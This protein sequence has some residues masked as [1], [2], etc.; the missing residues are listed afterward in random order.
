M[1]K[2]HNFLQQFFLWHNTTTKIMLQRETRYRYR[3]TCTKAL[4]I[5][6]D[7]QGRI[8]YSL[9]SQPGAKKY[10]TIS[11]TGVSSTRLRA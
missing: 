5:P 7:G 8:F 10:S 3:S 11:A 2:F 4:T 6:M 9:T 1:T